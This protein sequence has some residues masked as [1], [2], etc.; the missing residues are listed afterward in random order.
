MR[1]RP[2]YTA[3]STGKLGFSL[4]R[5]LAA[6]VSNVCVSPLS[7]SLCLQL[8]LYGARGKTAA[9]MLAVTGITAEN[10]EILAEDAESLT[11]LLQSQPQ[12]LRFEGPGASLV[13]ALANSI[14]V[15]NQIRLNS[16]YAGVLQTKYKAACAS[17][18]FGNPQSLQTINSWVDQSTRHKIPT[19]IDSLSSNNMLVLVNCA[20][21]KARWKNEFSLQQ[22]SPR[23]FH[24]QNESTVTVPTMSME[25]VWL[26]YF[27]DEN[28]QIAQ[29]DYTDN[30]FS[31]YII[32]PAKG[33]DL[34]TFIS[35]LTVERWQKWLALVREHAGLFT[36]PKF[37]L[38]YKTYLSGCLTKLGMVDAF[39]KEADFSNMLAQDQPSPPFLCID[40]IIHK[41]F[42]DVDE[43]GTEAAAATAMM[44]FGSAGVRQKPPPFEMIV[45][46]PFLYALCENTTGA[47]LFL[48]T[49]GDPMSGA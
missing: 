45:D 11:N 21:F 46:R 25:H 10:R 5:E 6:G 18:D 32:L 22:T 9:E 31:M 29:L 24:L 30:R 37:K 40:D 3:Q 2:P 12:S 17:L 13:L 35:Q 41:T 27:Q 8:A 33:L 20:Y 7:I 19:I 26:P 47:I 39:R 42:I 34:G 1:L 43:Q 23:Q 4:L 15:H 48:G 38:E 36:M 49:V 44:M 14:W 28:V 16:D